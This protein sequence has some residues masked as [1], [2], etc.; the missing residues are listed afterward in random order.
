MI[1]FGCNLWDIFYDILYMLQLFVYDRHVPDVYVMA[2]GGALVG[3]SPC[4]VSILR[5]GNVAC[6]CR[7]FFAHVPCRI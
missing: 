2:I 6:P 4:P 5:N 7:L 3:G 1:E